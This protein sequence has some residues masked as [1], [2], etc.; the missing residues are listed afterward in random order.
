M[1]ETGT[2]RN[3][4]LNC[5][6]DGCSTLIFGNYARNNGNTFYSVDIDKEALANA[7]KALREAEPF[8]YLVEHDS[9]EFLQNFP[10]TIDFLYLDSFD[11]EIDNPTPSQEHHLK[12]IIAAYPHLGTHSVVMIDDCDLPHGGKGTLAIE[13]L[14]NRGW[15]IL[16]KGYQVILSQ[17]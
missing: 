11:F 9:I 7:K 1:V 2:S 16:K 4:D 3:G 10:T 17:E 8:V 12:E 14:V 13:F 5:E 15:K 6:G